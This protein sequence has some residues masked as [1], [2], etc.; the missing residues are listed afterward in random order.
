MGDDVAN[1]DDL[2]RIVSLLEEIRNLLST[3]SSSVQSS[4]PARK[5]S[6]TVKRGAQEMAPTQQSG[7]T[8]VLQTLLD[9]RS[10]AEDW[11]NIWDSKKPL[12]KWLAVLAVAEDEVG[13]GT[14]LT[15][16]EIAAVLDKR[17]RV[18]GVHSTN[19]N[20]DLKNARALVNRRPRG[21]GY[22]YSLTRQGLAHILKR[23]RSEQEPVG[24][25]SST[26]S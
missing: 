10:D 17:F 14:P 13:N 4:S 7:G 3:G 11:N 5:S 1:P 16:S 22:E 19:I 23:C 2:T 20:R 6:G 8:S 18:G 21:S 26:P 12:D 9:S 24:A 25:T 15:A